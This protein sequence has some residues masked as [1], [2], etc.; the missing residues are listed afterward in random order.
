MFVT[1]LILGFPVLLLLALPF[2]IKH[3]KK[4][5]RSKPFILAFYLICAALYALLI[6]RLYHAL[7]IM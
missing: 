3:A 6:W 1:I 2:A 7:E 5:S 4:H